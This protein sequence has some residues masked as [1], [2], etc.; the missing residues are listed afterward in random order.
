MLSNRLDHLTSTILSIMLGGGPQIDNDA[1]AKCVFEHIVGGLATLKVRLVH[2]DRDGTRM[3]Q[4]S[5]NNDQ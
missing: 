4:R 3:Q 2:S 1:E 5:G